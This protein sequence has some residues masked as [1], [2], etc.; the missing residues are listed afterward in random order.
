MGTSS[1]VLTTYSTIALSS[2]TLTGVTLIAPRSPTSCFTLPTPAVSMDLIAVAVVP[3]GDYDLSNPIIFGLGDNGTIPQYVSAMAAGNPYILNLSPNNPV[4]GQLGLQ[5]PGDA[6]LVFDGSGMSLYTGN[7]STLTQVLVN[8]FYKQ[9]GALPATRGRL[10]KRQALSTSSFTVNIAVDSYLNTAAFKPNL[11]FG[12]SPCTFGAANPSSSLVNITWTCVYPPPDGGTAECAAGLKSWMDDMSVPSTTPKNTTQVLATLGPFLSL[13]GDSI[14]EL[15]PG[16]DPALGLGFTFMRQVESAAAKAVGSVGSSA[17]EVLHAFDS[18][19]LVLEDSGP[20]GTQTLGS[21][22][23]APPPSV[24]VNLA[25]TATQ[26]IVALPPRKANPTDNF[27][28]QIATDFKSIFGA[29]TQ[30]LG[31]LPHWHAPTPTIPSIPGLPS[32]GGIPG[33]GGAPGIPGFE[34]TGTITPSATL[35]TSSAARAQIPTVTVTHVLGDGWFNP[36]TYVVGRDTSLVPKFPAVATPIEEINSVSTGTMYLSLE[37]YVDFATQ[38]SAPTFA[39]SNNVDHIL[40]Q[41]ASMGAENAGIEAGHRWDM[42]NGPSPLT[43]A[44]TTG[45]SLGYDG[46]IVVVTTTVTLM[47]DGQDV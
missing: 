13:A 31:G 12:N 36:S 37:E 41:L 19:D 47:S 4:T 30:W 44:T 24:A 14:I 39:S 16:S 11:T 1:V 35:S 5:I 23:T 21:F 46:H 8:N 45:A 27:L 26:A 40:A 29:F 20:L 7:C 28:K 2:V 25:A 22:M 17:C 15:F 9:L 6:T 33:L 38:S 32:I 3:S 43:G 42:P 34:E 10:A 18:D